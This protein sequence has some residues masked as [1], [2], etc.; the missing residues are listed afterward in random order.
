[1]NYMVYFLYLICAFNF[2]N[3]LIFVLLLHWGEVHCLNASGPLLSQCFLCFLYIYK[4][5]K[6]T[7]CKL[8][9]NGTL[10][11]KPSFQQTK[12]LNLKLADLM[13]TLKK[14]YIC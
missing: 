5:K 10:R 4:K 13:Q 14:K 11:S 2:C 8:L 9:Q 1:M 3:I 6:K 7:V 12:S